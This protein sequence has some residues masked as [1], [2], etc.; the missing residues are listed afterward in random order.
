MGVA[1]P[2]RRMQRSIQ[3]ERRRGRAFQP[4]FAPSHVLASW[5]GGL[6]AIAVLGLLSLWSG[7]GLVV[8]PFGASSVLLFGHPESP[9]AQPRNLVLGNTLA[10]LIAVLCVALLGHTPWA[11]G[12]AV[13]LAIAVGQQ[14]R[15]L[16]PPAGAVALL[17]V[18]LD[19]HPL[20]VLTPVLTG[21]LLLVLI[22][23]VFHRLVPATGAYPHHWL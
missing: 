20:F 22:A 10:A 4:R 23:V 11:M 7:Y 8:A 14:L 6:L 18:L 19:A 2:L 15:C 9:L 13:G 21:S 3:L 16:H 17:G 5:L 12:L 1:V